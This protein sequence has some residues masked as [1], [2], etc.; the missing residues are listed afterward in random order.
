[1]YK[2]RLVRRDPWNSNLYAGFSCALDEHFAE[3]FKDKWVKV[4]YVGSA[5]Q[6]ENKEAIVNHINVELNKKNS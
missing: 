4:D 1:M 6:F 2:L 3:E 5:I